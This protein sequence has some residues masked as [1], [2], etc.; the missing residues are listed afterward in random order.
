M[1]VDLAN[2]ES[3]Q[4]QADLKKIQD[5]LDKLDDISQKRKIA[6]AA[7]VSFMLL[8]ALVLHFFKKT[9]K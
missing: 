5:V 6:G 9:S 4:I 1:N 3:V 2:K 7:V 8:F